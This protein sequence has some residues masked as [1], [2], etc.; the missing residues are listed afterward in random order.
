MK[1]FLVIII[2]LGAL[3]VAFN[4]PISL[5]LFERVLENR[6]SAAA[7]KEYSDGLHVGLCGAGS[8]LPDPDRSAPCTLVIAGEQTFIFDAGSADLAPFEVNPGTVDALFLTHFHSDHVAAIGDLM[9]QRWVGGTRTEPLPIYGPS[10][11]ENIVDGFNLAYAHDSLYRT[12]HHGEAIAPPS[13][14]GGEARPFSL[15]GESH[16]IFK[17]D[18]TEIIAFSVD[19]SP[20]EPAV[21]YRINY[22]NRSV[23]ISGDTVE[24]KTLEAMS[25]NV[26]LL[27]HEALSKKLV[28]LAEK[29]A[30]KANQ[31][32]MEKIFYDI[33]DYHTDPLEAA[34]L[35]Q[36]AN[37]QHLLFTH[38]VPMLPLPGLEAVFLEGVDDAF[39]GEFTL[40][41]DGTMISLPANSSD[42]IVH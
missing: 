10:G 13:G 3:L 41:K 9:M 11:V 38:I 14:K 12:A 39:D 16:V 5:A 30:K 19:H 6:L 25:K 17:N 15:A 40:G 7:G 35:A 34:Q 8:P 22:K 1:K 42:I 32:V 31:P 36:R 33:P 24:D 28:G 23:V 29:A 37:V 18:T 26:D 27:V 20:I 4:K 21:G 2:A